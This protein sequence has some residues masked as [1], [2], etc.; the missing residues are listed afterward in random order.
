MLRR[1][2]KSQD[3]EESHDEDSGSASQSSRRSSFSSVGGR[4]T[5][6]ERFDALAPDPRLSVEF[7]IKRQGIEEELQTHYSSR[8][9][10]RDHLSQAPD[11]A[12]V[13]KVE[14]KASRCC[15]PCRK[16]DLEETVEVPDFHAITFDDLYERLELRAPASGLKQTEASLRLRTNGPNVIQPYTQSTILKILGYLISGFNLMLFGAS[17]LAWLAW[18]PAGEPNPDPINIALA[19]I[20]IIVALIS[21]LFNWYQVRRI[22]CPQVFRGFFFF[23]SALGHLFDRRGTFPPW[24]IFHRPFRRTPF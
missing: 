22:H 9:E 16:A 18:K 5:S 1:S 12:T 19:V 10:A 11:S 7:E 14:K 13:K 3:Y 8:K 23:C 21:A 6:R 2:S 17:I 20:L 24:S 4:R 15:G